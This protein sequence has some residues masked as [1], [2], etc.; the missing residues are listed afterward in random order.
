MSVR[1]NYNHTIASGCIAYTV[2]SLVNNFLPLL[3]VLFNTDYGISLEKISLMITINFFTQLFMDLISPVFIDKI[4]YRVSTVLAHS[5]AVLGFL[6]LGILPNVMTDKFAAIMISQIIASMGGGIIEVVISPI[7]EA[8]PGEN[9]KGKMS[10]LH[11]FYC[12]GHVFVVLVSVGYFSIFGIES[13]NFLAIAFSLVPLF[14]IIYTMF[15]PIRTLDDAA[16]ESTGKHSLSLGKLIKKRIFWL[17]FLLMF[18]AGACEL[19]VSQWASALAETGLGVSKNIGDLAGPMSFAV[20]MGASR[21][22]Y[23]IFG[24]KFSLTKYMFFSA[25]LCLSSYL[26]ISLSTIPALSLMGCAICGFSVGVMWPGTYSL[27]SRQIKGSST[28]MFALLA[29]AGDLG[30]TTG[31]TIVGFISDATGNNLK[32]GLLVGCVFSSVMIVGVFLCLMKKLRKSK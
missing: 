20:L 15:V 2:Q 8:S 10:L 21:L 29:L 32:R 19:S 7:V 25:L 9:K 30:C 16:L 5:L 11:S 12:W 28:S 22:I 17:M 31:P 14:N 23:S 3:F 6:L 24:T 13:W 27:A 26:L 18:C 1:N 4:G